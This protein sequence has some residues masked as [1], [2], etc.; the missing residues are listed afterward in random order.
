MA[1]IEV[2]NLSKTFGRTKALDGVSLAVQRGEMVALI[3]ASGSGK[4]TLLRHISGLVQSDRASA[5]YIKVLG[6]PVQ[7]S[8]RLSAKVRQQRARIG[9]IFQQF[10]LVGR[11]S[12]LTNACVGLLG[13]IPSWRGTLGV[14]TRPEKARAMEALSRVGI[15]AYASQRASTLSGGQQQRAAIARA[16]VQGAEVVLAD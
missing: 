14:F 7:N 6:A 5:S 10:N 8:G 4:S 13:R 12:L 1:A 11:L 15:A 3:G 9:V 16:L 2:H